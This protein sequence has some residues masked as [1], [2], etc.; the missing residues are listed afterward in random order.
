MDP[1]CGDIRVGTGGLYAIE[2]RRGALPVLAARGRKYQHGAPE[3]PVPE[4]TI[5]RRRHSQW[6]AMRP[7]VSG[8]GGGM[9]I[10]ESA[11]PAYPQMGMSSDIQDRCPR[12][13]GRPDGCW[14]GPSQLGR[15]SLNRNSAL[16]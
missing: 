10:W 8:G 11:P 16:R 5:P 3:R 9:P 15:T 12:E 1:G 14:P 2:G 7:G 4:E 13:N 6:G